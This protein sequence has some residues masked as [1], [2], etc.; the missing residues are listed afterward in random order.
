MR[1]EGLE[2]GGGS[3]G[4]HEGITRGYLYRDSALHHSRFVR[5]WLSSLLAR[6]PL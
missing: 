2:P 6:G 4:P 1:A 5:Q 3:D